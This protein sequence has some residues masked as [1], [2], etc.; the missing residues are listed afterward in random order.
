M[1]LP[2]FA[3]DILFVGFKGGLSHIEPCVVSTLGRSAPPVPTVNSL[4]NSGTV[5]AEQ[6]RSALQADQAMK[7]EVTLYTVWWSDSEKMF[8]WVLGDKTGRPLAY[9]VCRMY[10]YKLYSISLGGW[11]FGVRV[12]R[13]FLG[14]Q[15]LQNIDIAS[16]L[17][18]V[19]S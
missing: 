19:G 6:L 1:S 12:Q 17:C 9:N 13:F 10:V 7:H 18:P 4:G 14:G 2:V 3:W 15:D 8:S 5:A 11:L 16:W